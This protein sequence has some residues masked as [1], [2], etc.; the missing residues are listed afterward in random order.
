MHQGSILNLRN[1]LFVDFIIKQDCSLIVLLDELFHYVI[2]ADVSVELTKDTIRYSLLLAVLFKEVWPLCE[3][4]LNLFYSIWWNTF[5]MLCK[6]Y[7][8]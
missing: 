2:V 7:C 6:V 8:N 4:F 3:V 5:T 1:D